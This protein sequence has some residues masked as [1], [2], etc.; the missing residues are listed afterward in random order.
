MEQPQII[1]VSRLSD[2][3][4][5]TFSDAKV[6]LIRTADLYALGAGSPDSL[7]QFFREPLNQV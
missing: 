2:G 4:L 3:V 1:E 5:V 6:T 7:P